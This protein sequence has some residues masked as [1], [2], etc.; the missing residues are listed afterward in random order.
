MPTLVPPPNT[1][2]TFNTKLTVKDTTS[3]EWYFFWQGLYQKIQSLSGLVPTGVTPGSYTNTN[4][5]VNADGLITAASS[6]TGGGA[7]T[8]VGI[9]SSTLTVTGSP[10]TGAGTIT[11]NIP[12][13]G[14]SNVT[15]DTHPTSPTVYD[16]EFEE[17]TLPS[18]WS[19]FNQGTFSYT[20][21][22][23]ALVLAGST[24]AGISVASLE[25]TLPAGSWKF[26]A[27]LT[28]YNFA[29]SGPTGAFVLRNSTTGNLLV[30]GLGVAGS[31]GFDYYVQEFTSGTAFSTTAYHLASGGQAP[32]QSFFNNMTSFPN[33]L[34]IGYDQPSNSYSF[35]I[36]NLGYPST[37]VFQF[38]QAATTFL[39]AADKIGLGFD[40]NSATQ[41][42]VIYDW[43][44]RLL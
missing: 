17:T 18:K 12:P 6:G 21:A 36:S 31:A 42:T 19:W 41:A 28:A 38:N 39:G 14:V 16:D 23:G 40:N 11:V 5:T 25:Q 1:I 22:D 13:S 35:F 3:R 8:S 7:V 26:A 24:S 2:P 34:E 20:L 37:Y 43:F 44:R 9:A 33:Y 15:P 4:L 27:K 30:F 32:Y 10:I 29:G